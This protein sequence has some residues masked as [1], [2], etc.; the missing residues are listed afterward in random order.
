MVRE[1]EATEIFYHVL[2]VV[3]MFVLRVFKEYNQTADFQRVL[4]QH[5]KHR[6]F[7]FGSTNSPNYIQ[8]TVLNFA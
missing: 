6:T 7:I 5:E 4:F 2:S 3:L 1:W 8:P